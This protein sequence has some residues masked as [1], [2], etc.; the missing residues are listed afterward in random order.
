MDECSQRH[1]GKGRKLNASERSSG[2]LGFKYF[3]YVGCHTKLKWN[4]LK[5]NTAAIPR[6][7]RAELLSH[8]RRGQDEE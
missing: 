1:V 4:L 2:K 6:Q 7:G 3:N 5:Q 8:N